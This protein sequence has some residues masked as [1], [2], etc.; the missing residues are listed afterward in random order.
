VL[1]SADSSLDAPAHASSGG[2]SRLLAIG[3]MVV[4]VTL[5]SALD[6]AA[7][8]LVKFDGLSV[9]QVVWSR[10]IVQFMAIIILVP[11]LGGLSLP[12]LFK[13]TQ[14][15][16]QLVRSVLMVSTTLFNF[17]A[18]KYL[19]LDQ[20]ITI[21]FLAPLVVALLAG[22]LLGEWVGWR[23][24]AAIGV[25]FG[26]ILI[27]VHPSSD[28]F[29]PAVIYSFLAMLAYA[30]F[31]L[32]TRHIA[33]NDPT[34]VTLFYSMF[35][36]TFLGAPF[37]FAQW[38]TPPDALAW[39]LLGSL[40]IFGGLGHWMF[41]H[42]YRLAPA[43]AVAPFLY[44]QLISMVSFGYAVFGDLPDAWTLTGAA[45]VVASGVYLFHRERVTM[46]SEAATEAAASTPR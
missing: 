41:I 45:V 28:G 29:H 33:K 21:V 7:K 39:L 31:M 23:R 36:G 30:L 32:L 4:A 14:L 12:R 37:A 5:F 27:A 17:L 3:L 34:M 26:G 44:L 10:F 1:P 25:G 16:W 22:P 13:T 8:Y 6:T 2:N 18:L 42:A 40:G 46:K 9:A 35:A 43:S 19:R 38:V 11:V 15:R 20:T 24:M